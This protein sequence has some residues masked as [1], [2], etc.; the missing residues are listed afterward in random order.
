MNILNDTNIS[1]KAKGLY[2]QMQ[3]L[4]R[5]FHITLD[6][7]SQLSTDGVSSIRSALNELEESGFLEREQIRDRGMLAGINYILKDGHE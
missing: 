4:P 6:A 2:L 3:F 1:Y 5:G 7:L